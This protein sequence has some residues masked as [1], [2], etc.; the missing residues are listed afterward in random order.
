MKGIIPGTLRPRQQYAARNSGRITVQIDGPVA[1]I[2]GI[3]RVHDISFHP[4]D[5]L[6]TLYA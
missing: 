2:T 1:R 4:Q 6:I 3:N 5:S